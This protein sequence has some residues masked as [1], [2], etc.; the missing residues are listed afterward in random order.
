MQFKCLTVVCCSHVVS[1]RVWVYPSTLSCHVY[2]VINHKICKFNAETFFFFFFTLEFYNY[3]VHSKAPRGHRIY[4]Y[5][6]PHSVCKRQSLVSI[7]GHI[8]RLCQVSVNCLQNAENT[9]CV[10]MCLVSWSGHK[11]DCPSRRSLVVPGRW[12]YGHTEMRKELV[13]FLS[14]QTHLKIMPS[15]HV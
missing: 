12:M 9:I 13:A 3:L 6:K 15:G 11:K 4:L 5:H 7:V 8:L 1:G 14:L 2:T 10:K